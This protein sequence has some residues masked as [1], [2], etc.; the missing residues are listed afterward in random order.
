MGKR[1]ASLTVLRVLQK[2]ESL[3]QVS[4][5]IFDVNSD[6]N[7][8]LDELARALDVDSVQVDLNHDGQVSEMEMS[9]AVLK[10][11]KVEIWDELTM[12]VKTIKAEALVVR[13][14][15]I[16]SQ[17]GHFPRGHRTLP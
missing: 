1:L 16:H 5:V 12:N 3:T 10:A 2:M 8:C 7:V 6:G 4:A 15:L 13:E 9:Q 11:K 14:R 17:C